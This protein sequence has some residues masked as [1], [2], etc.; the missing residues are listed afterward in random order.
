M[1]ATLSEELRE[2]AR[3][4]GVQV[5]YL[6]MSKKLK[7]AS[8]GS[9][10]AVLRALGVEI[11]G[12]ADAG[13]ALR[14]WS[15]KSWRTRLEPVIV[16]WDGEPGRLDLNFP[17]TL[18]ESSLSCRLT[19]E[20]GEVREWSISL[21]RLAKVIEPGDLPDA[22]KF[23]FAQTKLPGDLPTGYH[24]LVVEFADGQAAEAKIIAAP[25][26]AFD[27]QSASNKRTWGIFCPLHALHGRRSWGAGDFGDLEAL[28]DWTDGLGGGIVAT[29][30]M[31][32]SNFDGPSPIIS[33]YSPT[34]RLFWNEFYLDL[35]RIPEL[36]RCQAARALLQSE[37]TGREIEALR[38][39][40]LVEYGRQMRLKRAVLELL[41]EELL[42]SE[43]ERRASFQEFRNS[44][45]DALLYASFQAA[46]EDYGRDWRAWP[47]MIESSPE[48]PDNGS[49]AQHYHLYVQWL[50]DEQLRHLASK[51]REK[52]LAW[53]LDFPVG[54]D[55]NSFDVWRHRD[56][57]ATGAS[58]GCPPDPV[59]TKGQ[60]WGFPAAPPRSPA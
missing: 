7:T 32:A 55:F 60:N 29:L 47:S 33:P 4:Y 37:A 19:L 26:R 38:S 3:S 44:H 11:E 57:F 15:R 13:R 58:V 35:E 53:Y 49:R 27:G 51:A 2:L 18:C 23:A 21:R 48:I 10:L 28:I 54:V 41:A 56:V 12:E 6:D 42:S 24:R 59:F 46:G 20:S 14:D 52:G 50:A 40:N 43:G 31:L 30:P 39:S 5:D 1:S 9:L 36:A 25:R 22:E 8:A 34:S 45:F 17:R 16:A